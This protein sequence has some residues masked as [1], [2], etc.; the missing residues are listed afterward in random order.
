MLQITEVP[1]IVMEQH[2]RSWL[3]FWV[4]VWAQCRW[5]RRAAEI[6]ATRRA[7]RDS[8]RSFLV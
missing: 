8:N 6:E 7:G 4:E 2:P 5:I 3:Q 1:V